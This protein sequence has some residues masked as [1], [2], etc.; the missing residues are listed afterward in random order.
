MKNKLDGNIYAIKSI[1]LNTKD[2]QMGKKMVREVML[3]SKLNHENVVRYYTSWIEFNSASDHV[4]SSAN[5]ESV[6]RFHF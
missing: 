1:R 5:V 2:K 6:G 4:S 3:L